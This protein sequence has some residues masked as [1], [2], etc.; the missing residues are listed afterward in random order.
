MNYIII[1]MNIILFITLLTFFKCQASVV[2]D[3]YRVQMLPGDKA[4]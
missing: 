1:E 2:Q 3:R 4:Q